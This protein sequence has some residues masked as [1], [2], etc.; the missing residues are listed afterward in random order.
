M[1]PDAHT[2]EELETLLED[3][4][5][6]RDFHALSELFE[7]WAVLAVDGGSHEIRGSQNITTFAWEKW[8]GRQTYLAEPGLVLQAR[9]TALVLTPR[10]A[11]VVRRGCDGAWRYE[12]LHLQMGQEREGREE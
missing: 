8:Q 4:L 10:G 7:D 12:I 2:P 6:L 3:T 9:N 11:N 5:M 1:K